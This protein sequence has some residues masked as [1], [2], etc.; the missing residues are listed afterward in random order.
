M[1][2]KNVLIIVTD[3]DKSKRF[4]HDLFG[5]EVVL[6]N[7]ETI[8]LTEEKNL[9]GFFEKRSETKKSCQ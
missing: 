6:D 9:A 2:L 8:I 7:N 5:L 1:R 4:Y 3:I